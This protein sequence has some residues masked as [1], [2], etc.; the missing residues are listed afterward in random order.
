M[1]N[2]AT[3]R[4][5]RTLHIGRRAC[6]FL[7]ASCLS[8]QESSFEVC[9]LGQA[10]CKALPAETIV[11]NYLMCRRIGM[12][13]NNRGQRGRVTSTE[14]CLK[15]R[16]S[17]VRYVGTN[18]RAS[19]FVKRTTRIGPV[20]SNSSSVADAGSGRRVHASTGEFLG[21]GGACRRDLFRAGATSGPDE[22][23]GRCARSA[24]RRVAAGG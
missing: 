7:D 19:N 22:R 18:R 23:A 5:R 2:I 1:W 15:R 21:R 4:L 6:V 17:A 20:V 14:N 3:L 13:V 10:F 11:T 24:R 12:S 16:K 8:S 9:E